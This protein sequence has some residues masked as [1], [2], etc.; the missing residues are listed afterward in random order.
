MAPNGLHSQRSLLQ[1][2]KSL[3]T[4]FQAMV[5]GLIVLFTVY[6][7][8][9]NAQGFF[10][11]ID[12]VFMIT[13]L[14]IMGVTY[15][16]MGIY[17]QFGGLIRTARKLLFAWSISFAMNKSRFGYCPQKRQLPYE[18]SIIR[19][20]RSA[21]PA[22]VWRQRMRSPLKIFRP[23]PPRLSMPRL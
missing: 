11:T 23:Y 21:A 4:T 19:A 2:R 17:R 8:F 15:D 16:Q 9:Y 6:Y 12:A 18:M 22:L 1:R 20:I 3:T 5:D 13:L 14:A 10:S 7:A